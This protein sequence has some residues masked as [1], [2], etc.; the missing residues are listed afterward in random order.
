VRNEHRFA[1][2]KYAVSES[3]LIVRIA[4]SEAERLATP[5]LW[6]HPSRLT[7]KGTSR[8]TSG[9]GRYKIR[10]SRF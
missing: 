8:V 1:Q 6:R 5:P 3:F 10:F 7:P 4:E 2:K 9:W